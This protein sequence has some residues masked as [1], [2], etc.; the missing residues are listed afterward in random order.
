MEEKKSND[1][2]KEE[3]KE[4]EKQE[5]PESSELIDNAN[6]AAERLEKANEEKRKLLDREERIT[7]RKALSGKAEAGEEA[8]PEP[9]MS[10]KEYKDKV[11]AG[12]VPKKK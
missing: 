5:V 7:A 11:M 3:V 9:E 1:E 12:E 8:K 6:E 10:D 4:E 2:K